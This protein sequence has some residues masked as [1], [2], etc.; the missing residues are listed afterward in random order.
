MTAIGCEKHDVKGRSTGRRKTNGAMKIVGQ[1]IPTPVEMLASPAHRVLSLSARRVLARVEVEHAGHGG[2][3]N[4]SLPVT[5]NN[6]EAFGI[7]RHSIAPAIAECV[8]LG[9]LKITERGRSGNGDF[10]RANRFRITYLPLRGVA[11]T[12]DWKRIQ[13][14][15]EA[16]TIAKTARAAFR[17][18]ARSLQRHEGRASLASAEGPSLQDIES[19][20]ET[21]PEDGPHSG[22][23]FPPQM[24]A[25]GGETPTGGR[26]KPPLAF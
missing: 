17:A 25:T 16:E 11:P 24:H 2:F 13:T 26:E 1:F 14:D 21:P 9:F 5:F 18:S 4:G 15:A 22:G 20:G 23:F 19:G 12:H 3:E 10:R 6:F 8:A 7:D